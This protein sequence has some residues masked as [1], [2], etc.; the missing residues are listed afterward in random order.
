MD[1]V[2]HK[3]LKLLEHNGRMSHEE[4][5]KRL[6]ISRPAI[7]HRVAKLEQNHIIKGYCAEINWSQ[8][9]QGIQAVIFLN[10][11][12]KDFNDMMEQIIRIQIPGLTIEKCYRV[13]GQWCIMLKIRA[14]ITDQITALHDEMLKI[15][16]MLETFTMLILSDTDKSQIE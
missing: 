12:T 3:I 1:D 5:S 9:G 13:T 11:H 4:I 2:D 10:V 6:N 14:G 7:H 15:D 16:G 8:A